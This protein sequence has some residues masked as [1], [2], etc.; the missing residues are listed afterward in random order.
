[1]LSITKEQ[2]KKLR[3]KLLHL[4]VVQRNDKDYGF[5]LMHESGTLYVLRMKDNPVPMTCTQ[6]D[7]ANNV[8]KF[9][10]FDRWSVRLLEP[11]TA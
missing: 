4:T 10:G 9:L 6:L 1:M 8:A 3:A 11:A 5:Q 7:T 2:A